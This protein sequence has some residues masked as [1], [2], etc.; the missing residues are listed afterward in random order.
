[1]GLSLAGLYDDGDDLVLELAGL[2]GGLGLVLGGHREAVLL[3]ARDLPLARHIFGGVAHVVA[4][5]G[6]PQPVLDHGVDEL[7]VAHLGALAQMSAVRRLAHALL[8]AGN[9]D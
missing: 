5:E 3:L 2:L 7:H 4:V 9:D 8:A 6:I 1:R